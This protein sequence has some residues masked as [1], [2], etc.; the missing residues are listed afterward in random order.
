MEKV[1]ADLDEIEAVARKFLDMAEDVRDH[2]AW[3]YDVDTER[4]PAD[5]P[6]RAA[7]I[8]YQ[9]SL[10]AVMERLCLRAERIAMTLR[11]TAGTYRDADEEII[12]RLRAFGAGEAP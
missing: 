3:K 8:T 11:E 12:A 6:V 9:Q 1:E 10:R 7:V 4:W 2:V 5:D